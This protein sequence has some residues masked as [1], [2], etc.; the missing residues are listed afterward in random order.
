MIALVSQA[1]DTLSYYH[2][3]S[4]FIYYRGTA[5]PLYVGMGLTAQC[6]ISTKCLDI[7]T[8]PRS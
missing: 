3:Y 5:L 1:L 8:V 7:V 6:I 4:H 2:I